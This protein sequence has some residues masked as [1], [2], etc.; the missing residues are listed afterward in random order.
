MKAVATF[1]V[2]CVGVSLGGITLAAEEPQRPS[3][4]ALKRS[5]I[6]EKPVTRVEKV[7]QERLTVRRLDV[8][9]ENGVIRMVLAAPTPPPIVDGI[10]YRR[11]FPVSGLVIYDNAGSERGGYGV[12]DI[13]GTATVLAQDHAHQ[14]AI[15][16]RVMPDG[17]VT[18]VV[19][20][21]QPI[22]RE[23]ALGN[24]IVPASNYGHRIKL[25]VAADGTP[26]IDLG[27]KQS[28]PRLRLTV[29]EAGFGAI[30]FL[31]AQ[32]KVVETF[33]PE[34]RRN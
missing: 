6:D 12:A 4:E 21:R 15:G 23:P 3:V 1:V 10:Q 9:D 28:R 33:A 31:D 11:A 30:E 17:S 7:D 22:V 24:R 20:E 34:A 26:S 29:T 8:V 19:N 14:D 18:F 27:D 13:E 32:G 5:I 25:G 16:W 2:L